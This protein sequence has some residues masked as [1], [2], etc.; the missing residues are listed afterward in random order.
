MRRALIAVLA[1]LLIASFIAPVAAA[2][3]AQSG[4]VP[5]VVV[6]VGPSG[7]ATTRYR[8]EARAAAKLAR[9]YTPDVT[10]IYSPNATW[11]AVRKALQGA[12]LVI[13]MGHGN[14]WPSQYRN[15]L[16]PPTQNGFGLNPSP[17]GNDA[18]HQY[19]G[20]GPIAS[21]VNLAKNAVVLLNHLCYASGNSEPG[22]AE[23]TLAM[24][25]QRVDNFAAGFVKAGAAAV[26]AEAYA[27]P[28]HM[29]RTVLAGQ[30]SIEAAWRGAPTANHNAFAFESSRSN[31]Y[32]AQMDPEHNNS[33]FS[34]SIVLKKGL[35]SSDVLRNARG[36]AL[37]AAAP[38][39]AATA[40]AL[41]P[42]L[43]GSGIEIGVPSFQGSTAA[44]GKINY[45][46]P[47]KIDDRDKLPKKLQAS[48]RW[49]LIEAAVNLETPPE[50]D[51]P[52]PEVVSPDF[53]LITP[54]RIGDVIAPAKLKIGRGQ[55]AVHV[56][57]PAAP[58]RYRLT[59]TLHDEDGVAYDPVT[60]AQVPSLIFRVTGDLDAGF[61]A[62]AALALAPGATVDLKVPVANLGRLTWGHVAFDDPRDPEGSVP[63]ESARMTGTWV[64]LGSVKD[65][66]QD[67][68]ANA[69]SVTAAELP[70][71]FKPGAVARPNLR[72]FAPSVP[73]DYLL[74]LDV[75]TP[76]A[77]SLTAR[78]VEPPIIR[79]TVAANAAPAVTPAETPAEVPA[80]TDATT[81]SFGVIASPPPSLP[82]AAPTP[83][84]SPASND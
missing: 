27:S 14:G 2:A 45:R 50:A 84:E 38:Q 8:T 6:V 61:D 81:E 23:G 35:A 56:A 7:A 21:D 29:V 78:G 32:V 39:S 48:A 16:Y 24:A 28:N 46:I 76:E 64:A 19:F 53:G 65:P 33:G 13:Y 34:R 25:R 49:D 54:E 11:P 55:M 73:G 10:E 43:A 77:G 37:G 82:S 51:R 74:I 20:E 66:A 80:A 72:L 75:F 5:K 52:V 3:P 41:V 57:T 47:F 59:V 18:T 22:V 12:S 71:G 36:S 79:V 15:S 63:S 68:A 30:R 42:T 31:G 40:A 4:A 83:A 1:S 58:G 67:D 44:G 69:A 70:A 60:Q 62:P 9:H 26:V 17:G